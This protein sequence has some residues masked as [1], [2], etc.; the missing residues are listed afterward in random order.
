M[1]DRTIK[2]E[3]LMIAGGDSGSKIMTKNKNR[4]T[5]VSEI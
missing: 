2:V 1:E 3:R 4:Q 5:S